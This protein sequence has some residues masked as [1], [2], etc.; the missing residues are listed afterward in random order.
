[1]LYFVLILGVL[2]AFFG[3]NQRLSAKMYTGVLMVL[4]VFRYGIGADYFAY[5]YLYRQLKPFVIPE[6]LYGYEKQEAGFRAFGSLLKS[7]GASYPVY[8]AVL[9]VLTLYFIYRI[10]VEYSENPTL[11]LVV[12]YAFF[13]FVWVYSGL[14]QGLAMSVG[15]YFL[16]VALDKG[17]K[18]SFYLL[19]ALL[20][21]IHT[22][23]VILVLLFFLV[24]KVVWTRKRL[25]FVFLGSLGIAFIPF[26]VLVERLSGSISLFQRILPY[27]DEVF[28]LRDLFG[29]Q[30][31]ARIFLLGLILVYY[32]RI[33]MKS[34]LLKKIADLYLLSFAFYFA[35]QF[36]ELTAARISVYGR[37]MEILLLPQILTL[38]RQKLEG[39]VYLA[40]L[41]LLISLYF[42]KEVDTMRLQSG[43][44]LEKGPF[45]PYVSVLNK[46]DQYYN[47][48]FYYVL[49][50][51]ATK[52]TPM[53]FHMIQ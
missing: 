4:A 10:C 15:A 5:E 17:K 47:T 2:L 40:G 12:Y 3:K 28:T 42:L 49:H 52:S 16:L 23:S 22:S 51:G 32:D 20:F 1:M 41:L 33:S 7:F 48:Y 24:S 39:R 36:S 44:V 45:V 27:L 6:L 50:Y 19:S 53:N 29:F 46:G 31:L 14:R 34:S 8:L 43:L 38:K 30:A 11:S 21:T 18:I 35:L 37:L 26:G 13:Y 25:F 9:A